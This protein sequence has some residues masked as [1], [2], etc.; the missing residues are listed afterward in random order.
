MELISL[1]DIKI[2]NIYTLNKVD[3]VAPYKIPDEQVTKI[4]NTGKTGLKSDVKAAIKSD[5]VEIKAI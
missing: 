1:I 2:T 4:L 5:K 3:D